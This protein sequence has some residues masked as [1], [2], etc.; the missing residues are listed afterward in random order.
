MSKT[1]Q[2]RYCWDS[3]AYLAWLCQEASA[4]I[5]DMHAVIDE[6][7]SGKALM[8]LPV[9]VY[10]EVLS[11]NA[12]REKRM[13]F[14]M[15]ISHRSVIRAELSFPIATKAREIRERGLLESPKRKLRTG[16]AQVL[17]T[18]FMQ[19]ATVLHSLDRHL[20]GLNGHPTANRMHICQPCPLTGQKILPGT[21]E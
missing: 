6:V 19:G 1:E 13:D 18:A 12:P 14:E 2:T 10:T 21:T 5:D 3:C 7:A 4:P 8:I 20:L 9:T 11:V 16:D 17:A 15:F